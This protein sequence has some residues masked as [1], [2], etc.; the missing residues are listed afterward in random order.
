MAVNLVAFSHLCRIKLKSMI[1][2]FFLLSCLFAGMN[3][4]SQ[5]LPSDVNLDNQLNPY[6]EHTVDV[7]ENF[8]SIGRIYNLSPKIIAPYNKLDLEKSGLSIGQ[9]IRI[10]LVVNNF[11]QKGTRSAQEVIIPLYYKVSSKSSLTNIAKDFKTTVADLKSWNQGIGEELKSDSR[12]LI[13]FLKV[14]KNVSPLA[15][16]ALPTRQETDVTT[17]PKDEKNKPD[18]QTNDKPVENKSAQA[19]EKVQ[20][21][22]S[23]KKD[24]TAANN[25]KYSGEGFFR[26]EYE[27]QIK[28]SSSSKTE[29]GKGSMFKSSSG[30]TDGKYYLII[31]GIERGT[32]VLIKNT[33]TGKIIYAKVLSSLKEVKENASEQFIIS[34]SA[35]SQLGVKGGDFSAE[36]IWAVE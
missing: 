30:W 19:E 14:D 10:P 17:T 29:N 23:D 32:I 9:K 36:I 18:Q 20:K 26:S 28:A 4:F 16:K 34:E 22:T 5:T 1:R 13:G 3:S 11:W 27:L 15:S 2:F 33:T 31:D 7:K 25:A 21:Q 6:L 8:Y 12:V 35:A 24:T